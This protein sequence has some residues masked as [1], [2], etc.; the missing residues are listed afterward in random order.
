MSNYATWLRA[1]SRCRQYLRVDLGLSLV[2][3]LG[4]TPIDTPVTT[5]D[6]TMTPDVGAIPPPFDASVDPESDAMPL[7]VLDGSARD[8]D[9]GPRSQPPPDPPRRPEQPNPQGEHCEPA[10]REPAPLCVD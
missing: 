3:L 7:P 10:C 4:C 8:P 5:T 1:D 9:S 6:P 2:Y